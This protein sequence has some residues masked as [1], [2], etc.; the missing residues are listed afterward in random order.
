M[1]MVT[2]LWELFVTNHLIGFIM[3]MTVF[4]FTYKIVHKFKR[5]N[6]VSE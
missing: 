1:S 2:Y 3:L 6:E 4:Y 5:L